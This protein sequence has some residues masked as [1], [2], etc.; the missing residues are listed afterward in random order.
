MSAAG[1]SSQPPSAQHVLHA[2]YR[3]HHG[4]LTRWLSSRLH[5]SEQVADIA[6]DTYLRLLVAPHL[7]QLQKPRAFLATVA[8]GLLVD[9]FRRAALERAYLEQLATMPVDEHPA[10]E[11]RLQIIE[12]LYEVDRLLAGL[13]SRA[14]T[15]FLLDR[16]DGVPQA[17][18]AQQLGVSTRRV[19]QYLAQAM[20]CC[21]IAQFG[22]A[23]G[24]VAES[25]VGDTA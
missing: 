13:S 6:Q 24:G 14:R 2:L 12:A 10:P 18:I 9:H 15:A 7:Q 25:G 1:I 17:Q 23:D 20:R 4:W 19:R 21:Y 22:V 8:K 11:Q 16:V 5:C 3:D